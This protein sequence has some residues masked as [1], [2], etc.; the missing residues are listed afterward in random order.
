[1][2]TD[3]PTS[4]IEYMPLSTLLTLFL[5]TDFYFFVPPQK[6]MDYNHIHCYNDYNSEL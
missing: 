4:H 3:L 6:T 5:S 2:M 1:M